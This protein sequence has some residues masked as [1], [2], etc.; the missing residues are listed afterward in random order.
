MAGKLLPLFEED[1]DIVE[2][3]LLN[4][5][6]SIEAISSNLRS[7]TNIRDA[8]SAISSNSLNRK[9]TLLTLA[10]ILVALPNVFFVMYGMNVQ[11]PFQDASWA[12]EA[13][14]SFN[15]LLIAVIIYA[16]RKKRII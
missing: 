9:I 12:Y 8:Y 3:L 5:E 4:N 7:I 14:G 10:T 6:Q 1:H 11:L 2:D 16:A 15:V 13:I